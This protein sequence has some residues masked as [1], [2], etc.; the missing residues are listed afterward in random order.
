M[1]AL[2]LLEKDNTSHRFVI[3]KNDTTVGRRPENDFLIANV[4]VSGKHARLTLQNNQ[5]LITDLNSTNGTFVNGVRISAPTEIKHKDHINFGAVDLIFLI[6]E[7]ATIE[8]DKERFFKPAENAAL[9][10]KKPA[11]TG[12]APEISP[13]TLLDKF[14]ALKK[15]VLSGTADRNSI[16]SQ[17]LDLEHAVHIMDNQLHESENFQQKLNVLYE[18]GKVINLIFEEDELLKTILDL[19][20]KVMKAD[21]GFIMLYND[22]NE[23]IPKISRKIESDEISTSSP[24]FS[25][26]IS[27]RVAETAESIL[28]SDAQND[29]RFQ[30]GASIISHHIRSVI[31]S[32]LKNKDQKVIGVIYVGSN[33]M[34]NVFSKSDV[35][36]LEAF[37]NHAAIAI[38]NA[39]LYED[40][41]RKEHLKAA[42]E[43]YVSKQIAEKIISND[44]SGDIRFQPEKREVT[45]VFSD[46]RGF[47][48]LAE[49]MSPEEMVEILNRYFTKMIDIIFK[50][51]GTLDKFIGD[52]I[53][54]M[55]GAPATTGDDAGNAVMAA[56]EMQESLIAF[57]E[58]QIKLGKPPLKVGIGINSGI[59][60]VG[61]I[62][63][64]QRMEYTA[65][66][67][68]VN[69]ASRLEGANKE[70]GTHIMV[71]EWTQEK[72]QDKV[73]SRELD[74]IR[75]K[76]KEKPV[77]VFE[78]VASA[79][80]GI[81][82]DQKKAIEAYN[83]GLVAY[84]KQKWDEAILNFKAALT[85][86][87]EDGPSRVYIERSEAFKKNPPEGKWDGVFIMHTK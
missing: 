69:L 8:F 11:D 20:L 82:N 72:V 6:D 74:L 65:I 87:P 60:V 30:S 5:Y 33:V 62:G 79:L 52:A 38:E 36:L 23:L 27:K 56:L 68:S 9:P 51:G 26:T 15:V 31:C 7:N 63:S 61:N 28:T 71:S 1:A 57:N 39:R 86:K 4:M 59:V 49:S 19:G 75:V 24:T 45:L 76:G 44:A 53:M 73:I 42:L 77:K 81:S 25:T 50:Y 34:S 13:T 48:T 10:S 54:A 41:R 55:F 21:C 18:I 3:E 32:P 17:F 46:V 64:D 70:Y 83:K 37:S 66:G 12:Y 14:Q 67:D 43:R 22:R 47:T 29:D 80:A 2:V 35:D 40:K 85:I 84:R 78:V 58:E 16:S